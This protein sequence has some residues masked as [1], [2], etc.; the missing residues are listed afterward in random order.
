M[1][2]IMEKLLKDAQLYSVYDNAN[3][4]IDELNTIDGLRITLTKEK[5][6][7]DPTI[8]PRFYSPFLMAVINAGQLSIQYDDN[9][10]Q[11][12]NVLPSQ[13]SEYNRP[14][15][16]MRFFDDPGKFDLF[17]KE[18]GL[19]DPEKIQNHIWGAFGYLWCTKIKKIEQIMPTVREVFDGLIN[20]IMLDVK[21]NHQKSNR[22]SI[23]M[24]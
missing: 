21:K 10:A 12:F 7:E 3:K 8:D 16:S 9:L 17:I 20:S 11:D 5:L 24:I 2:P 18:E 1:S 22:Y 6:K 4:V 15:S 14:A 13:K 23:E 19:L